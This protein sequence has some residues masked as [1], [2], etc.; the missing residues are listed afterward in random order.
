MHFRT[1][2]PSKTCY[3]DSVGGYC[4]VFDRTSVGRIPNNT[5]P[6]TLHSSPSLTPHTSG[7]LERVDARS[8]GTA[9]LSTEEPNN[10][11]SGTGLSRSP[12]RSPAV[13]GVRGELADSA[14][15]RTNK[16]GTRSNKIRFTHLFL[17][18]SDNHAQSEVP[19]TFNEAC[20]GSDREKWYLAI[21]EEQ[22][23]NDINTTWEL[24]D[25]PE[26][27]IS[28]TA[29]WVSTH[30][31]DKSGAIGRYKARLVVRGYRQR[32]GIDYGE[33]FAPIARPES[34][35]ILKTSPQMLGITLR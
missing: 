9:V 11:F 22:K 4:S 5:P 26:Q 20:E 33:T 15:M 13:I 3:L 27:G 1:L 34:I 35:R 24:V 25:R 10:L 12:V 2:G 29:K 8:S 30:E 19:L 31:R 6:P 28:L 32:E 14:P 17:G 21:K 7:I 18:A 23:A 16:H